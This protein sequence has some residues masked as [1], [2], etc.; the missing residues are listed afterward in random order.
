MLLLSANCAVHIYLTEDIVH[1][2]NFM[3]V[4][5]GAGFLVLSG[6]WYAAAVGVSLALCG[7]ALADLWDHRLSVHFAFA[8]LSATVASVIFRHVLVR[9]LV[10]N[11]ALR[12][13]SERQRKEMEYRATHDFLT[14]LANRRKFRE[15]LALEVARANRSG[16]R[17]AVLYIDL[18]NF[19]PMNDCHG[20]DYGDEVLRFLAG[21]LRDLT[22]ETDLV[23]RLG[24]DEFAL[25]LTELKDARAADVVVSKIL[26]RFERPELIRDISTKISLSIGVAILP[27]DAN[28]PEELMQ[29]A[30]RS[31]YAHK[32]VSRS[33][34]VDGERP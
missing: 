19:K 33:H 32:E 10:E 8:M 15:H 3:L 11:H 17:V 1:T 5:V 22:R 27:D 13:I 28:T 12:L 25:L 21:V 31:M 20:H 34:G 7:F 14:G 16:N 24:G 4:V 9:D 29:F 18:D 23:C 30:D 26:Q 6:P 2:T